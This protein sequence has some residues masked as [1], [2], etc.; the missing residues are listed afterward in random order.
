MAWHG[1]RGV[2]HPGSARLSAATHGLAWLAW[3]AGR[4]ICSSQ[5]SVAR[6]GNAAAAAR[7]C[8]RP[9]SA[10]PGE[11]WRGKAGRA[12]FGSAKHSGAVQS[13]V[14]RRAAG[15]GLLGVA[16]LV[17]AERGFAGQRVVEQCSAR[18][19]RF[20]WPGLA[21]PGSA[22]HRLAARGWLSSSVWAT[23]SS[24]EQSTAGF[25]TAGLVRPCAARAVTA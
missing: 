20:A 4:G 15:M 21:E 17:A 23:Q 10:R 3:S 24:A 8:A 25:G 12:W 16:V 14:R 19:A 18:L 7:G 13:I 11:A 6:H 1:W 9:G 5:H 2:A 22:E